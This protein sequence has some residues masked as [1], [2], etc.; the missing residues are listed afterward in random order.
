MAVAGALATLA[1]VAASHAAPSPRDVSLSGHLTLGLPATSS[2]EDIE[3]EQ[4]GKRLFSDVRLSVD[5]KVSCATCH[6][7]KMGFSDHRARAAGREQQLLTRNTPSLL[8]VV[9][10]N[11]LF[12]D[13]R[14]SELAAQAKV[15]LFGPLEHGLPDERALS[16]IVSSDSAYAYAFGRAFHLSSTDRIGTRQVVE[17]LA[18]Y[19][20]TLIAGGSPFDEFFYGR[21]RDAMTA[22]AVDGFELFRGRAGCA[23]CHL[24]GQKDA[25]FTDQQFHI[26]PGGIGQPVTLHLAEL[27]RRVVQL[28]HNGDPNEVDRAVASDAGI[29]ALGR[30][31]VSLDPKDIGCFK[32]PSLRNVAMTAPY[33]HDGR[34]KTLEEAIDLELYS[35]SGGMHRP[36][37]LTAQEKKDLLEFL[38]DL[39]SPYATTSTF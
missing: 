36:I 17:A 25:L 20:K 21:K 5:G 2:V 10:L 15:P 30:F 12:W 3:L 18:T 38:G 27:T 9:Y 13:G 26:S 1:A 11:S 34:V 35:R 39:T 19:E 31:V 23:S 29:A 32:T 24:V 16:H 7:P 4:L 28:R 37:A 14:S 8:N 6:V 33:M 22:A